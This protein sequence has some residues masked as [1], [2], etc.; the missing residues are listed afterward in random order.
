MTSF[1]YKFEQDDVATIDGVA[2]WDVVGEDTGGGS[3]GDV[4]VFDRTATNRRAD[5]Q[6]VAFQ[7]TSV[8]TT[9]Y[10][11]AAAT[12]LGLTG[13]ESA[14]S[15][16]RVGV[17]GA[18]ATPTY[19]YGIELLYGA[20]GARTLR[21]YRS[22]AGGFGGTQVSYLASASVATSTL[23]AVIPPAVSE[24]D[25]GVIQEIRVVVRKVDAGVL[26]RG[27]LNEQDDNKP[28]LEFL[29]R[30]DWPTTFGNWY[31]YLGSSPV[32]RTLCVTYFEA[33][34]IDTSTE[35]TLRK[36]R[37]TWPQVLAKVRLR[38]DGTATSTSLDENLVKEFANA[39]Q[40]EIVQQLGDPWFMTPTEALSTTLLA[41][42][43]SAMPEFVA[44]VLEVYSSQTIPTE[45][46]EPQKAAWAYG[47]PSSEGRETVRFGGVA[48]GSIKYRLRLTDM[49]TDTDQ[50]V[51]PSEHEDALIYGVCHKISLT[52]ANDSR[53]DRF[54]QQYDWHMKLLFM[55]HNRRRHV[56][57]RRFH[58]PRRTRLFG[59]R[60]GPYGEVW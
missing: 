22:N 54:A 39:T 57:G 44:R 32:A 31:F 25:L 38:Y 53:Q 9:G 8:P 41:D 2:G 49:A 1:A 46:V 12:V 29:D 42:G 16:V 36:D 45:G 21:L 13:C 15:S 37:L 10:Q 14:S 51:I 34:D 18:D 35:V 56:P 30:R 23:K 17:G 52:D 60:H 50:T 11:R 24:S 43:R 47:G 27:Y 28:T 55:E 20:S 33:E 26:L 58:S 3:I 40:K 4:E 6:V 48:V 19:G 7:E 5:L 59:T